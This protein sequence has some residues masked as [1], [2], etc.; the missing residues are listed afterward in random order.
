MITTL[1]AVA[2]LLVAALPSASYVSLGNDWR[3]AVPDGWTVVGS[4]GSAFVFSRDG[5]GIQ[6]IRGRCRSRQAPFSKFPEALAADD[7]VLEHAQKVSAGLLRTYAAYGPKLVAVK[8][9][10]LVTRRAVHG[11]A[12][13]LVF[14]ND[15]GVGQQL[16][17]TSFIRRDTFCS[18]DFQVPN[19]YFAARDRP[20]YDS[21]IASLRRR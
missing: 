2:L 6:T 4:D 9:V 17:S 13:S 19:A 7:S 15:K 5:P 16:H 14:H 21:V 18:I 8:P 10:D 3:V 20:A 11:I 1:K 12:V